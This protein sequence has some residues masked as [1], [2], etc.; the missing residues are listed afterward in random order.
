[1][2]L[3]ANEVE[4]ACLRNHVPPTGIPVTFIVLVAAE[5]GATH[6]CAE[7][8]R[9]RRKATSTPEQ[10]LGAGQNDDVGVWKLPESCRDFKPIRA[11]HVTD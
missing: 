3:A 1:M 4:V 9:Q 10:V 8:S 7:P 6:I 2:H 11:K 5:H